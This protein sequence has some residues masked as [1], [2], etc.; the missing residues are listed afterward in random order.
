MAD[1]FGRR[2]YQGAPE[3]PFDDVLYSIGTS[4]PGAPV[5]HN[6]PT[7]LRRLPENINQ[8]IMTDLAATDI[9]RDRERGVPRYCAFRRMLRMSGTE[10]FPGAHRQ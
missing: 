3:V 7:H 4:Y 1:L 8:G 2:N 9:M 10:N 5:L 6:Y